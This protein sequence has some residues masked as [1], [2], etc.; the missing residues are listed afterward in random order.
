MPPYAA[1]RAQ[2]R[3]QLGAYH[4]SR[5]RSAGGGQC[6]SQCAAFPCPV[7]QEDP[8]MGTLLSV[9]AWCPTSCVST[10]VPK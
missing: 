10:L 3:A 6:M 5:Q 2:N 1:H 4:R 9:P 8:R 7:G